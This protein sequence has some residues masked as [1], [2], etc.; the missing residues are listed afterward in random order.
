MMGLLLRFVTALPFLW[1]SAFAAAPPGDADQ[2]LTKNQ[3]PIYVV[4]YEMG[5][6]YLPG[7]PFAEQPG[8]LE[9]AGYMDKLE[10]E[11]SLVMGGPCFDDLEALLVSG[12]L[13]F[14]R[15]DSEEAARRLVELD[16]AIAHGLM[17]IADVKPMMVM[18]DPF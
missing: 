12:A 17:V 6:A 14:L 5:A 11:G 4:E 1:V 2:E 13:L 7:R 9:H 16:P 10:A 8:I 15:V 18:I 3:Q